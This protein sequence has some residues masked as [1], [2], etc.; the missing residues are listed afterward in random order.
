M[1]SLAAL[2]DLMKQ[3]APVLIDV[4]PAPPRPP[5]REG[6]NAWLPNPRHTI[7]GAVWLPNVGFGS[8]SD[9]ME[10]YFRVN[11]ARLTDGDK[12]APIVLFCERDCWMSWNAAKRAVEWGYTGVH[13]FPGRHYRLGRSRD[14]A[15][16]GK[17]GGGCA[18]LTLIPGGRR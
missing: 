9:E 7:P 15:S 3:R 16:G 5:S 8:L 11:L 14:A 2:T 1:V 6:D 4:M 17:T 13:W 12:G 10:D 18:E